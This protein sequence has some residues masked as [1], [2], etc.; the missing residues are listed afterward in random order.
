MNYYDRKSA[1][2]IQSLHG[3]VWLGLALLIAL[4][5]L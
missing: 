5:V 2:H 4:A 3:L 1:R